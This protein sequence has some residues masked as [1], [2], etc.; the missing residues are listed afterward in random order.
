MKL[1]KRSRRLGLIAGAM[2]GATAMVMAALA[3]AC[4]FGPGRITGGGSF[5]KNG[6]RVTHGFELRCPKTAHPQ[7]LQVNWDGNRFHLQELTFAAC[8]DNTALD[9]RPPQS[10]V[11]DTYF[12]EGVGRYN[13]VS[14]ATAKWEFTD[15]GEPGTNDRVSIEIRDRDGNLVLKVGEYIR[16]AGT[17]AQQVPLRRGNH[18]FHHVDGPIETSCPTS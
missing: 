16:C 15:D 7:R 3:Y 6:L 10:S 13:G 18:Q 14:G 5:F 11:L 9:P 2:L 1:R 17:Q 4:D 12:G 8:L